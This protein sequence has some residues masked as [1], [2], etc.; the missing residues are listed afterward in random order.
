VISRTVHGLKVSVSSWGFIWSG[1][2]S[3]GEVRRHET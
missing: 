2:R 1:D 3:P